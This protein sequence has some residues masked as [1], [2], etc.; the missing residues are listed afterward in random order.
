MH[1]KKD[2]YIA[3]ASAPSRSL[4]FAV[5]R[6]IRTNESAPLC[7]PGHTGNSVRVADLHEGLLHLLVMCRLQVAEPNANLAF[8]IRGD[9]KTEETEEGDKVEHD[10]TGAVLGTLRQVRRGERTENSW[11]GTMSRCAGQ[12]RE[13]RFNIYIS[14]LYF[15][16]F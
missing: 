2:H 16:H 6:D 9:D 11:C 5:S 14:Y 8:G 4:H 10:F 3:D 15:I 13:R 1:R 7:L 12:S